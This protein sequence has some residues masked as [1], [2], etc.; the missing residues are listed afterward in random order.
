MG[1]V[2]RLRLNRRL[3]VCLALVVATAVP[4]GVASATEPADELAKPFVSQKTP[5]NA[6][7]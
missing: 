1:V 2:V 4:A 7:S 5:P 6:P 3:L